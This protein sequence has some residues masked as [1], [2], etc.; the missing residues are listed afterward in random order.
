MPGGKLV[1]EFWSPGLAD[2][3]LYQRLVILCITDHDFVDVPRHRGLVGHGGVL[4]WYRSSLA[5]EGI[6][7]RVSRRL[8]VDIDVAWIDPFTDTCQ[9]IHLDDVIF[10]GDLAVVVKRCIC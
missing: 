10:F 9:P 3:H 6:V 8:F 2:Q 5:S 7:R 4:V 1:A